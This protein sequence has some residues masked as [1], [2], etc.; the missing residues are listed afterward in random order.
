M[1]TDPAVKAQVESMRATKWIADKV[2]EGYAVMV[3]FTIMWGTAQALATQAGIQI[4]GTKAAD[5]EAMKAASSWPTPEAP[6]G[7]YIAEPGEAQA[8][9]PGK[10]ATAGITPALW[11]L[12]IVA[13][14]G[15]AAYAMTR[16]TRPRVGRSTMP[17]RL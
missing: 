3:P 2:K 5:K 15:G 8:V 11:A 4:G 12:G 6:I 14:I 9:V 1:L 16:T 10:P 7:A 17:S 13:V